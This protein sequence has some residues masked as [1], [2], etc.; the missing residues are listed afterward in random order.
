MPDDDTRVDIGSF[1]GYTHLLCRP[2]FVAMVGEGRR[3]Q[4]GTV[5]QLKADSHGYMRCFRDGDSVVIVG[6]RRPDTDGCADYVILASDGREV[7]EVK[8]QRIDRILHPRPR[9]L[10]E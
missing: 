3:L 7:G 6:F 9:E 8:P 2:R 10:A 4:V 1:L 5:V